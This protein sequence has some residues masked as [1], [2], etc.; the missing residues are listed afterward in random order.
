MSDLDDPLKK[1]M[2]P[3]EVAKRGIILEGEPAH[4]RRAHG[5]MMSDGMEIAS[6]LQCCHCGSH[7][8]SKKGSGA[9]RTFC[10]KC[11]EVTCGRYEC[12]PCFP[13]EKQMEM[14]ERSRR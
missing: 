11:M 12:D 10:F 14:M 7:F 4:V 3:W 2:L 8:L 6:T 9:R 1:I 13:Y 5:A